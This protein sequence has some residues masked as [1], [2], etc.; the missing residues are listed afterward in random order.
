S[1]IAIAGK[2]GYIRSTPDN[3]DINQIYDY[4]NKLTAYTASS[5][6]RLRLVNRYQWPL[7]LGIL[8]FAGEG[9]WLAIMPW[10]RMRRLRNMAAETDGAD[11]GGRAHA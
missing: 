2:G 10:L 4:I 3:S 5:D 8:C 7:G 9:I 11:L 6:V 1:K